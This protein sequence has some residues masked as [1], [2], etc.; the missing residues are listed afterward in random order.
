[1]LSRNYDYDLIILGGGSAGMVAG[2]AAGDAGLRTLLIEKSRM[3]GES[4]AAPNKALLQA[5]HVAQQMRTA[6]SLGF[7]SVPLSREDATDVLRHV[8]ETI[9]Q[10]EEAS[11]AADSLRK[12]GVDIRIGDARF[13]SPDAIE[14]EEREGPTRLLTSHHFLLA[15]GCV[16]KIPDIQGI[17]QA[18]CVTVQEVFE[19]DHIPETLLVLG[20]D[21]TAVEMAQAF[22]RLGSRVTMVEEGPRILPHSDFDVAEAIKQ[23][24]LSEGVEILE[25]TEVLEALTDGPR[26][27]LRVRTNDHDKALR[28]HAVLA[29]SGYS[30]NIEGLNLSAAQVQSD[31]HGVRVN[32]KLHTTGPRVWAC[33]DVIG[34]QQLPQM[35]EYESRLV[36]H[37]ILHPFQLKSDPGFKLAP[38]ITYT[39]PE[40]AH[41]GIT[42][43]TAQRQGISYQVFQHAFDQTGQL[44]TGGT[45]ASGF[46]KVLANGWHGKI[47]GAHIVAPRA[48][49]LIQ[50]WITAMSQGQS[51]RQVADTIHVYPTHALENRA[52]NADL[53]PAESESG[54]RSVGSNMRSIGLGLIGL[55][56]I[57]GGAIAVQAMKKKDN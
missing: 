42:E 19:L 38:W 48:G 16:P 49:D 26:K 28:G 31:Q 52:R 24:L 50:E 14:L 36:A 25:D 33:G 4:L 9:E 18:G 40:A 17:G 5:A 29:A 11:D 54:A 15:T 46:V 51:M 37:N 23:V 39:E 2:I 21:S 27:V 20:G 8:R 22:S 45:P 43:D 12:H 47:L 1:M 35:V 55:G 44:H 7:K 57:V 34:R 53:T 30:P 3:G 6:D 41:V 56:L 13:I 32:A 10:K